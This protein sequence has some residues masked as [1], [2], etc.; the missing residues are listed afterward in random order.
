[1]S[2]GQVPDDLADALGVAEDSFE[3]VAVGEPQ[4][5]P[6]IDTGDDWRTQFTK[7]CRLLAAAETLQERVDSHTAT[8][9][10]CFGTVERST[11]AYVLNVSTDGIDDFHDHERAYI[12]GIETGLFPRDVGERLIDL[13][14]NNR[15]E[16]YYGGRRATDLQANSMLHLA[17]T[18]HDYVLEQFRSSRVCRCG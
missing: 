1:M 10:L 6:G 14:F 5:E 15:A 4:P 8:I 12:R 17:H 9:E 7:A 11:E 18:I 3:E 16:S 2:D 13:Y